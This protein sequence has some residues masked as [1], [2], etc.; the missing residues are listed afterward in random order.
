[1]YLVVLGMLFGF[2]DGFLLPSTVVAAACEAWIARAV[3]V[4]GAVQVRRAGAIQ[5]VP[6]QLDDTFCPGDI[7]RVLEQSRLAIIA[8][9]GTVHRLDQNTT[10]TIAEPEPKQTFLLNLHAGAAYFFSRVPR[11]LKVITPFVNAGVEGTEFFVMVERDQVFLSIFEGR[12]VAT[13][14][15]GNLPLASGQSAIVKAGQAPA[16]RVVVR[17]RDAV[18]WAL[19]YPPIVDFRPAEFPGEAAWQAMVRQSIQFYRTGDLPRAFASIVGV[20]RDVRDPRF[21]TYRAAL[22]LIVGRVEDPV[23]IS[24][25]R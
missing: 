24:R 6:V 12:V 10:I 17:P 22:L 3:S 5:W 23:A 11:S 21:F 8:Q 7:I 19:H 4:Q 20:P 15:A 18:Q 1:M 25:P 2:I 14:A 9:N 13:N 16:P